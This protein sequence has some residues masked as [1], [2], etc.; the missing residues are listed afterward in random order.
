MRA[1]SS[2]VGGGSQVETRRWVRE[3]AREARA[4]SRA[5][6]SGVELLDMPEF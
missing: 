2:A 4:K 5:E 1:S 3:R 6:R